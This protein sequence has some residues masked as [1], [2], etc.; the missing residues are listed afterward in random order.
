MQEKKREY[1]SN[2]I[3]YNSNFPNLFYIIGKGPATS[4]NYICGMARMNSCHVLV[5]QKT[6]KI[7]L[8]DAWIV[9]SDAWIVLSD[10]WILSTA[11][12]IVFSNARVVFW[13]AWV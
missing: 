8:S 13:N 11:A 4:T 3:Y 9:L 12:R 7:V 5:C 2:Y 1:L 10:A 6:A